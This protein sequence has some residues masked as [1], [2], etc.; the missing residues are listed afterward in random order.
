M[1]SYDTEHQ[2]G[3][4]LGERIANIRMTDDERAMLKKAMKAVSGVGKSTYYNW[5][6]GI[7]EPPASVA[8]AWANILGV[9]V[10]QLLSPVGYLPNPYLTDE[11]YLKQEL[12]GGGHV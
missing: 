4:T 3:A 6:S 7:T 10:E 12:E 5:L 9:S 2:K 1:E 11:A 8:V